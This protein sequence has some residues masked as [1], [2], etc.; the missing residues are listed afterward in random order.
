MRVNVVRTETDSHGQ[1]L[2]SLD[3][4]TRELICKVVFA[5]PVGAGVGTTFRELWALIPDAASTAV[6]PGPGDPPVYQLRF[7]PR[8]AIHVQG[9][10]LA[11]NLWGYEAE[12]TGQGFERTLDGVDAVVFV[13]DSDPVARKR[14]EAAL[15]EV[16]DALAEAGSRSSKTAMLMQYNKRDL[17][18]AVA[19]PEMETQLNPMAWPFVATAASRSQGLQELLD[20]ISTV[21][22]AHLLGSAADGRGQSPTD[23]MTSAFVRAERKLFKREPAPQLPPATI[24]SDEDRTVL[25]ASGASPFA[26]K[27]IPIPSTP[28]QSQTAR[29]EASSEG[30][31]VAG[32]AVTAA[33]TTLRTPEVIDVDV[34]DLAGYTVHK[35]GTPEMLNPRWVVLP[36]IA[37]APSHRPGEDEEEAVEIELRVR[38]GRGV[39]VKPVKKPPAPPTPEGA[40]RSGS[41][42][43][44]PGAAPVVAGAAS[45]RTARKDPAS[46]NRLM[47]RNWVIF[48]VVLLLVVVVAYLLGSTLS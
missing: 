47:P 28:M 44:A 20:R 34:P 7:R 10:K 36:F 40:Q 2:P 37:T 26:A 41:P 48:A 17:K 31:A 19:I 42:E 24:K 35:L 16:N 15:R 39:K 5:G 46:A 13:A 22:P 32:M 11:F 23:S 14:N 30:P 9:M 8:P 33:E 27:P 21:V 29:E 1:S 25:G 18:D 4:R 45:V 43:D 3:T 12:P 6:I 38:L